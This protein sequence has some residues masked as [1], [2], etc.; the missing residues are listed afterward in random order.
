M[1]RAAVQ[2][3]EAP[4]KEAQAQQVELAESYVIP[5][6]FAQAILNYLAERPF[7]EVFQLVNGLTQLEPVAKP[8]RATRRKTTRRS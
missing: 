7:R 1:S 4:E 6:A 5:G 3:E 8:N 2:T